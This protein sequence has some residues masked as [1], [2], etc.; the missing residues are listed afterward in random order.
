VAIASFEVPQ[1]RVEHAFCMRPGM[2]I[3]QLESP[4]NTRAGDWFYRTHAPGRAMAAE[5]GV[6]VV[7]FTNVHRRREALLQEADVLVLNM[8]CDADLL[9]VVSERA[10]RG[11]VTVYEVNDDVACIQPSN[12]V[13]AY[14]ANPHHQLLFRRLVRTATAAQFSTPELVRTYG[15]LN[16]RQA[17]FPNQLSRAAAPKPKRADA[18]TVI[19]WGGSAGHLEDLALI[20]EPL[21]ELVAARDDVV[22]HLMGSE[23]ITALF[24][25]LAPAKKRLVTPGSLDDYYAFVAGLDIG[26]APLTDTGFNRCRSDVKFLEY[27]L[28]GV[29]PVVRGLAP[30]AD[31][32]EHGKTGFLFDTNEQMFATLLALLDDPAQRAHVGEQA[33]KYAVE[34]RSERAHAADR[35]AFYRELVAETER[36]SP[37]G[38]RTPNTPEQAAERYAALTGAEICGRHIGLNNTEYEHLLHDALVLGQLEGKRDVALLMLRRAAEL[39]PALYQPHLLASAVSE[40]PVEELDRCLVKNPRSLAARIARAVG[41][42][43]AGD[44]G[45][46]VRELLIAA[47]LHPSYDLPYLRLAEILQRGGRGSEAQEFLN[48]AARLRQP[49]ERSAA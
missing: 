33:R 18:R 1:T 43:R 26:L 12:P 31:T 42:A 48:L 30:Y 27:A 49:L 10:A 29:V 34:Q 23:R 44:G 8:V 47:E 2:L 41:L 15:F 20:A 35:I 39:E 21:M 40:S 6:F 17:V 46:A 13:A 37:N 28:H 36:T 24:A 5:E 4:H 38:T 25:A 3:A 9:T 19:G 32:V 11:Q 22:L 7:D 16:S 14:F 45:G